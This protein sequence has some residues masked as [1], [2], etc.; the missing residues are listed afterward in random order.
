[1]PINKNNIDHTG[2][3]IQ[4]GGLKPGLFKLLYHPPT[5]GTVKTEPSTP[6]NSQIIMLTQIFIILFVFIIANEVSTPPS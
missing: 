5:D 2:A 1:M 3:K 6:A 4:L